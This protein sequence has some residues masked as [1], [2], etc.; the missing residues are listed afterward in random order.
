VQ[1]SFADR[2]DRIRALLATLEAVP[3]DDLQQIAVHA[4]ALGHE[5]GLLAADAAEAIANERRDNL[6][7]TTP[8]R[9]PGDGNDP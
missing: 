4:D 1:P 3:A 6:R 2:I 7:L 9:R 5:A 8:P